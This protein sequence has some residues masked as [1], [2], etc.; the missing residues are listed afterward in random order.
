MI[1]NP[2]A[3]SSRPFYLYFAITCVWLAIFLPAKVRGQYYGYPKPIPA[4][5]ESYLQLQLKHSKPDLNQVKVLLDLA[6]L[7]YNKPLRKQSDLNTAQGYAERAGKLSGQL[8]Y[9]KGFSLAQIRM[10]EILSDRHR[11]AEADALLPSVT[12]GE[13]INMLLTLSYKN[14]YEANEITDGYYGDAL[15]Y[16]RQAR[17][18]SLKANDKEKEIIAR[19][20]L[21]YFRYYGNYTGIEADF[22]ALLKDSET[23]HYP[24]LEYV[25]LPMYVYYMATGDYKKGFELAQ[26]SLELEKRLNDPLALADCYGAFA[27]FYNSNKQ[28]E[29]FIEYLKLAIDAQKVHPS[30]FNDDAPKL[31]TQ[32]SAALRAMKRYGEAIDY[33]QRGMREFPA[34]GSENARY[35]SELGRCYQKINVRKAERHLLNAYNYLNSVHEAF[36]ADHQEMAQFYVETQSYA[37]ARPYLDRISNEVK[38][39]LKISTRSEIEYLYFKVDSATGN[40]KSA[41]AHLSRNKELDNFYL[42]EKK[43]KDIQE[44]SIKYETK[45][46]EDQIKILNQNS[47]LEK[48]RLQRLNLIKNV[49]IVGIFLVVVIAALFYRQSTIRKKNN[50]II[51][52]KNELL[53]HL[54]KEKEWLLKEVH[55]RVKNNLHTVVCLLESQAINLQDDALHAIENCQHRI[56]AMSLIHQKLYQ[57]ED[58]ETV[59]MA[60]FLPEFI[61]YLKDSTGTGNKIYFELEVDLIKVEVSLAIP[62]SLIINEAVTNAIKYAFQ[63]RTNG[64]ISIKMYTSGPKVKLIISDNGIGIQHDHLQGPSNSLG[65]KLI[66][67][68]AD[69]INGSLEIQN[70]N[71]TSIMIEF[72]IEPV[73]YNNDALTETEIARNG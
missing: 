3:K 68:L 5:M 28:P 58:I 38:Q 33:L 31:V 54:L 12:G 27:N 19:V 64:I 49:T 37:K 6:N 73:T 48:G 72:Q 44:L 1:R 17:D 35:E 55:H 47:A 29:K 15:K 42:T 30:M 46:K 57:S 45:K 62:L 60:I 18:L 26:R 20:L 71:G 51:L 65:L 52:K 8:K 53:E 7:Y 66:R 59:N 25:Y 36:R 13:R 2:K 39:K 56:Y 22:T 32:V 10:A 50:L 43:N 23:A 61:G 40:Y 34:T 4:A 69:D 16:A 14:F 41:I 9:T 24:Y 63:G 21:T 11:V 70:R 67:G